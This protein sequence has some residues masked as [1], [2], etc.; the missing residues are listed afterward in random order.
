MPTEQFVKGIAGG[1]FGMA[2]DIVSGRTQGVV[3]MG[4]TTLA[5]DQ[6]KPYILIVRATLKPK[7]FTTVASYKGHTRLTEQDY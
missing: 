3:S 2:C 4:I 1:E 7:A 5:K 6:L